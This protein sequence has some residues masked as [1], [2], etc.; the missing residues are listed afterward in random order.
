[1]V[2][3]SPFAVHFKMF[4][5]TPAKLCFFT[6]LIFWIHAIPRLYPACTIVS[7]KYHTTSEILLVL[8]LNIFP[9]CASHPD[10]VM[11]IMDIKTTACCYGPFSSLTLQGNW[12][13]NKNCRDP[14]G[15]LNVVKS[16]NGT[17]WLMHKHSSGPVSFWVSHPLKSVPV[18]CGKRTHFAVPK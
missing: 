18:T 6:F 16:S 13:N 2:Q 7:S 4:D 11:S 3:T 5:K 15:V 1:M 10:W 12:S 8:S 14:L 17:N 9:W